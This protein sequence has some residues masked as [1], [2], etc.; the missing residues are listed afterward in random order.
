M[1]NLHDLFEAGQSVWLDYI[2]RDMLDTGE[3]AELVSDGIRGLTSNPTIFMKAIAGSELYDDQIA[4]LDGDGTTLFEHLAITDIRGAADELASV[5]AASDGADGF[6]SLEVSPLLANDT[7]G[8]I[9][10]A[11]RLWELVDRRNLMIKVPAT[12]AGVPALEELIARNINV[13]STLMFSLDHYE[14][15]AHAYVRGVSRAA[16]PAQVASVASF[17]VSRVDTKTDAALEK[18][19]TPEAT[20]LRGRAAVANAKLAYRRYREV[21]DGP[22]FSAA[23]AR[24][25]RPQR[26]LWASTSTKNPEY[27]DVLYVE[28]LIG[29]NTVNTMPPT[30]IDAFLDHGRVPA[31]SLEDDVAGAEQ[32]I[33]AIGRLGIDFDALTEELQEEG[34]AAFADSFLELLA[35]IELKSGSLRA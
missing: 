33:R 35:A 13:N 5:Y 23:A 26:V 9:A 25:A 21:F 28:D 2:R 14:A 22:D 31:G 8:T 17:F 10:E 34:V 24:G 15:I 3:L 19:G 32:T 4:A 27:R 6:V 11:Q 30:T 20:A 18:L 12:P 29:P 1:A 16:R 7:E